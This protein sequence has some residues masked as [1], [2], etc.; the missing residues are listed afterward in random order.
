MTTTRERLEAVLDEMRGVFARM[1]ADAVP[2][3]AGSIIAA[4]R[5]FL[6]G[7][8]RNGLVL[9]AFAM[10]LAHLGLDA[11]FVGQLSAPPA[12][13]GDLFLVA[14]ALGALPTG[15]ALS[16]SA[17]AAGAK[18]AVVSARPQKVVGADLLLHLPAQTMADPMT[19]VLALGSPFELALSL[20][21]DLTVAELMLRLDRSNEDLAARHTN[22]L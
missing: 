11:H 20:L 6:Y 18:V 15:D 3:L 9:Q 21:C 4:R 16:A 5:I 7:A 17:R 14:L 12:A 13:S 1:D 8:G 19:S 22:L 2:H 10:R